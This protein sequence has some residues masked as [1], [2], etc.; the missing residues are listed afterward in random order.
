MT[1]LGE[2]P[3]DV[4]RAMLTSL[5]GGP[6]ASIAH[7][8]AQAALFAASQPPPPPGLRIAPTV[9]GGVPAE[10]IE[11]EEDAK[12]H[13]FLHLHGGGYVMGDPGGSRGFTT[14]LALATRARVVSLDYRLAPDHP[15]PA[16][17]DDALAAYADVLAQG[18]PS[19]RVAIG[20][21]SAGGGLTVALLLAIRDAGL[22]L[23]A[24]AVVMSPWV[25]LTCAGDSYDTRA[26]RDPL[27]TRDVLLEMADQYLGGRDPRSP[28]ASPAGAD[29]SGLPPLLIQVGA[30]EVLLDDAIALGKGA[31]AAG[32]RT[33]LEIWPDMIHVWQM[34][35]GTLPQ[36]DEAIQ[37]IVEFLARSWRAEAP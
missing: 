28:F 20:G 31:Q 12:P 2:R 34:F 13:L 35:A 21:E 7:R 15:F 24:C 23:P 9:L 32:V 25:D 33:Q 18:A 30:D 14:A 37:R 8:R 16:A 1:E 10:T 11:V 36:A 26:A 22:P 3:I 4:V 17:V 27:L 6:D 19:G 29:L 5:L